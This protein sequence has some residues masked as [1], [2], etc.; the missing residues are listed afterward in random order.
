MLVERGLCD[1]LPRATSLIL[2][3]SVIVEGEKITKAGFKFPRNARIE[4][5]DKIPIYVS[6]G[7]LKLKSAFKSFGV[8]S[9]NKICIDLGAST[10]GFT[11]I[12]LLNGA[13]KIYAF[14]VGYG[15]MASRLQSNSKI[16]LKDRFNVR[17]LS[18]KELD[19]NFS[20]LFIVMDLS[21]ISLKTIFPTI[22]NLKLEARHIKIEV[23]SLIK[24][25]FECS[26]EETEK[27]IVRNPRIHFRILKEILSFLKK[28]IKANIKGIC[29]SGIRGT[30]GNREFFVYWEL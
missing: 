1:D 24:P 9:N 12:L 14:D 7:A 10:G 11:E 19:S 29:N 21:F 8:S 4:V 22:Q 2:S 20:D 17:N 16:I 18:W 28:E 27:G 15:Q 13:E 25:Q 30:S 26:P 6:R 3:G 5:L 23:I